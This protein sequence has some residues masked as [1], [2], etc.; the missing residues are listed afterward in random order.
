MKRMALAKRLSTFSVV[1]GVVLAMAPYCHADAF[2]SDDTG[3]THPTCCSS[4]TFVTVDVNLINSTTAMITAIADSDSTY[5]YLVGDDS[6]ALLFNINSSSF[7]VSG[8][9]ALFLPGFTNPAYKAT[10]GLNGFDSLGD[11]NIT[12]TPNTGTPYTDAA[13][14]IQ[15]TVTDNSGSWAAASDVLT[16]NGSGYVAGAHVYAC[17]VGGCTTT[18]E[19]SGGAGYTGIGTSSTSI[20]TS[21]GAIPEPASF[22]LLLSV[23]AVLAV[24]NRRLL[25]VR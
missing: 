24:F 20:G 11:F 3:G 7:S 6:Q 14:E 17:P 15:I 21:V 2:Y 4:A 25:R 12:I 1:A 10:I 23:L 13:T 18:D 19:S 22:V 5:Q 9:N 16:N 8:P